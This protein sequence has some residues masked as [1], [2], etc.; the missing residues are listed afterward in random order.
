MTWRRAEIDDTFEQ[1]ALSAVRALHV[2]AQ[3][4]NVARVSRVSGAVSALGIGRL[5]DTE[6]RQA[7]ELAHQIIGSAGTFGFPHASELAAQLED[8]FLAGEFGYGEVAQAREWVSAL[9]L[10]L[11]GKPVIEDDEAS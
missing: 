5:D 3:A 11:A 2:R 9:Q 7:A 1:R 10:D 8:F 6:R 4:S